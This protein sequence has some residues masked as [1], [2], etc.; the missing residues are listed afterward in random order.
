M[1][2]SFTSRSMY[3]E[4]SYKWYLHYMRKLRPSKEPSSFAFGHA[5]DSA[6]NVLLETKV[7]NDAIIEFDTKWLKFKNDNNI[8]YTKSDLEEHLLSEIE[9][10]E[11]SDQ[12]KSW[13]SLKEKGFILLSEYYDQ[14][15]PKIKKVIKVQFE[16]HITNDQGDKLSIKPDLICEWENGQI[17]LVDNKTS[18]V[19]YDINSVK[20]SEQLA[21]YFE[22]LKEQYKLDA[23]AFIVMPKKINKKKKPAINIEIIID[24]VQETTIE[25]TFNDYQIALDGIKE[26]QFSKNTDNCI[27]KYGPCVYRNYCGNGNSSGLMEKE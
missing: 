17:L 10:K 7:L 14:V 6:L 11:M 18:S 4:C 21:T 12:E 9:T 25:K 24:T 16:D 27:S 19:K 5:I 22:A 23:C 26:G 1:K 15:L 20:E 13:W 8:K 2:I 3:N